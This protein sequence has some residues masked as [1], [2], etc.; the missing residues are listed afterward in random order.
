ME[1]IILRQREV[2]TTNSIESENV[3]DIGRLLDSWRINM[4]EF[5]D[6]CPDIGAGDLDQEQRALMMKK[7]YSNESDQ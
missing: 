4:E 1:R 5:Y 7:N 6:E 2:V 3:S